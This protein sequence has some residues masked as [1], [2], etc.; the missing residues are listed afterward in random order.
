MVNFNY[1]IGLANQYRWIKYTWL[2]LCIFLYS[3][4]VAFAQ[5]DDTDTI[6]DAVV[7]DKTVDTLNISNPPDEL[8]IFI[9]VD[10]FPQFPGGT[11]AMNDYLIKKI[12][13]PREALVDR[14][15]GTVIVSYIVNTDGSISKIKVIN[16]IHKALDKVATDA[17]RGMPLWQAGK[18]QGKA[19]RTLVNL[20]IRFMLPED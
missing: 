7:I 16:G 6:K 14:A 9:V 15:E 10:E 2:V 12:F 3:G 11:D 17:V 20:P 4:K 19:V 8:G 5:V 1:L 18:I 13:Y